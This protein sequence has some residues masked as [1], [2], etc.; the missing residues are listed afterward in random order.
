MK[1]NSMLK[2]KKKTHKKTEE[3]HRWGYVKGTQ[4]TLKEPLVTKA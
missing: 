4:K 3:P 2:K 1:T